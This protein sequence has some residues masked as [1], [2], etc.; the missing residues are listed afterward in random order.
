MA[1]PASPK[2]VLICE[3][4]EG[5]FFPDVRYVVQGQGDAAK[6]FVFEGAD[7]LGTE[8]RS[9]HE[10]VGATFSIVESIDKLEL[11]ERD[12]TRYVKD[13]RWIVEGPYQRSDVKNANGRTY[14]R[15]LWERL[16]ESSNS[17]V[18][19]AVKDRAMVGV[20]EHPADGRTKG[21][22]SALLVTSLKLQ[23]DGIV[24]GRS[25]LLDTPD[26]K[27]LQELTLKNVRWGVSSRG[28]GTID[29]KGY[30]NEND[31]MVDT[32]DAVM[33]P[34]TS[35][36]YP[37]LV[38]GDPK[39]L[40]ED[41]NSPDG[42]GRKARIAQVNEALSKAPSTAEINESSSLAAYTLSLLRAAQP[43]LVND[44]DTDAMAV[45]K[46]VVKRMQE[47]EEIQVQA[48]VAESA[49]RAAGDPAP[50]VDATRIQ[51][52]ARVLERLTARATAALKE[53]EDNAVKKVAAETELGHLRQRL[54][55]A[56]RDATTMKAKLAAATAAI[57][58]LKRRTV[59]EDTQ[60][61]AVDEAI[62]AVP[63]LERFKALLESVPA[64]KVEEAIASL[65]P[66]VLTE[67]APSAP[68]PVQ[69]GRLPSSMMHVSQT[70]GA[71]KH[72]PGQE[73]PRM[74]G[75]AAAAVARQGVSI[76][77]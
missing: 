70:I 67:A 48:A 73:P 72:L 74:V 44:D 45:F 30:V 24:W 28:T 34:S 36:A 50:S 31:F 12:G 69:R 1:S 77:D 76:Q 68:E 53:A 3:G 33:R 46:T 54:A 6:V 20:F 9:L 21:P 57:G 39:K 37:R 4:V 62:A 51:A 17:P 63:G 7:K 60:P 32:W 55:E 64:D 52:M 14:S 38:S 71:R 47:A 49:R 75:I 61:T 29:D 16:I 15:K 41:I 58:D 66:E 19:A 59:D 43:A 42:A 40:R 10:S 11:I 25:E 2:R 65:L 18:V 8:M 35:G 5:A 56:M 22:D 13:G 26:G 27:I 23:E